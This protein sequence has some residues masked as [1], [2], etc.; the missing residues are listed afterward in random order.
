M[1]LSR[2]AKCLAK[3]LEPRKVPLGKNN[4]IMSP[5]RCRL[6]QSRLQDERS[7]ALPPTR[8]RAVTRC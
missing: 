1:C 3:C 8:P 2:G 4:V 7:C 5:T 6:E